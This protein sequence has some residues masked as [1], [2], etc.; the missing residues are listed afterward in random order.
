MVVSGQVHT[1][2][3][4]ERKSHDEDNAQSGTAATDDADLKKR[5]NETNEMHL[6]TLWFRRRCLAISTS[7]LMC[8]GVGDWRQDARKG[9]L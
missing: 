8:V 1:N 6:A 7:H 3:Q 9:S 4:A 5:M 2:S